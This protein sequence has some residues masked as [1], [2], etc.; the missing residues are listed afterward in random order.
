MDARDN[1]T[2]ETASGY[3]PN[4]TMTSEAETKDSQLPSKA[5]VCGQSASDQCGPVTNQENA[6]KPKLQILFSTFTVKNGEDI[7]I[8]IPVV[9]EPAPKIE[10]KKSDQLVKETSRLM[11]LNKPSMTVLHIRHAAR[12]HSGQYSI[13][14]S[15]SAGKYVGEIS[16][17]VL[18]K[19]DPPTGP[20]KIDEVGSDYAIISWGPPEYT[21]GCQLDN[22]VVEK[23]ETMS[24]DWQTVS[25]TTVRT[26]IKVTK[27]KTGG[28]YQF[29]IFAENRYGKST[30]ITSPIVMAQF[31][32]CVPSAPGTPFVSTV[33]KYN[34]VVEW[35]P[36]AKDGGSPITGYHIERKEKNSIL[37]TKLNKFLIT[38]TRF[39]TTGLEE[40]IEYEF[41]VYAENVAGLSP[42]SKISECFV[43]RDPCGPPGKP[44]AVV[45]TRENITLQWAKP[46]YD[47]GSTITGYLVEKKELP[48]GR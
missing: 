26:T 30:A 40:G 24:T 29:R 48:D 18:E 16:L 10:W 42:P 38:D 8:E 22:Y 6:I 1:E 36:P 47:G 28:E 33:T 19:P 45:I 13:E 39:K 14:A 44:E 32:F 2:G 4:K 7:K 9:G 21:G 43:A 20:V 37:W 31:P 23:R 34:M 25:A 5:P 41:R 46:K 17:A 12:E 35:E 27:L 15:N 3:S 11:I